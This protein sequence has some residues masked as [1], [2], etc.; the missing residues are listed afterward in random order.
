MCL[1]SCRSTERPKNSPPTSLHV[2]TQP[3][4][5]SKEEMLE[6]KNNYTPCSSKVTLSGANG[7][8]IMSR[9]RHHSADGENLT[10]EFVQVIERA[11]EG[12]AGRRGSIYPRP[13]LDR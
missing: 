7:P 2:P 13:A 8:V 6:V 9:Y 3:N 10:K 4:Y 12:A 5:P 11:Q 1:S